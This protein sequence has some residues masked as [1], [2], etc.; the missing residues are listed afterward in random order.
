MDIIY[1]SAGSGK[2]TELVKRYINKIILGENP[3]NI[4]C[5][6][7][8]NNS[9]NDIKLKIIEYTKLLII[10]KNEKILEI[11]E[12]KKLSNKEIE[13]L[14]LFLI[15]IENIMNI[16]TIDSFLYKIL[17]FIDFDENRRLAENEEIIQIVNK[18]SNKFLIDNFKN[19]NEIETIIPILK[20]I[21]LNKRP[22][23]K[24]IENDLDKNIFIKKSIDKSN[25]ENKIKNKLNTF[26]N[27][28]I[29][30]ELSN[31]NDIINDFL[32][33]K[34]I[35]KYKSIDYKYK[36]GLSKNEQIDLDNIYLY[37]KAFNFINEHNFIIKNLYKYYQ[38]F[39]NLIEKEKQQKNIMDYNDI[40]INL[41]N[42]LKDNDNHQT[43][44][45]FIFNNI[46]HILVDEY[47]DTSFYQDEILTVIYELLEDGENNV[48]TF[49][50]IFLV[51][52]IKQSIYEWRDADSTIF[53]NKLEFIINRGNYQIIMDNEITL[54]NKINENFDKIIFNNS[55]RRLH[56]NIV[57]FINKKFE[58]LNMIGFMEHS[59]FRKIEENII[60]NIK[61][62][63]FCGDENER[64]EYIINDIL[65]NNKNLNDI[66]IISKNNDILNKIE[67]YILNNNIDLKFQKDNGGMVKTIEFEFLNSLFL[68][69]FLENNDYYLKKVLEFLFDDIDVINYFKNIHEN[70]NIQEF[71]N[72]LNII[73]NNNESIYTKLNQSIIE[74]DLYSIMFS[75]PNKINAISI[76]NRYIEYLFNI[77]PFIKNKN[78]FIERLLNMEFNSS[79]IS[80]IKD[81]ENAIHLLT[82]HK[83]KGL[84]FDT[85]YFLQEDL[86]EQNNFGINIING[87]IFNLGYTKSKIPFEFN[88][89]KKDKI[90]YEE[91]KKQEQL[92]L[93][94]VA[95]TRAKNNLIIL[96]K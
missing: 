24:K 46:G 93:Y 84:E 10:N 36:K 32:N 28:E 70:N 16:Y 92:K 50:T 83:S 61:E 15:D 69:I 94:Y 62:I 11:F 85:V 57:E 21:Y 56:P 64:I 68:S 53:Q 4:Y 9:V 90:E 14:K 96:N 5:L 27:N 25:L 77:L 39:E 51:G 71:I 82:I 79:L 72:K 42:I 7:F 87:K 95:L 60:S 30:K 40:I 91:I 41:N 48:S 54:D 52:D 12:N 76:L 23:F 89:Y 17:K 49:P 73:R 65:T 37:I 86:F 19:N 35:N 66:A 31:S 1:A 81:N 43:F 78:I 33:S 2:T 13:L 74:F 75:F 44:Q 58:K 55:T 34:L 38:T 88:S 67:N 26:N 20:N 6:T 63:E 45:Y 59:T 18:I 22:S 8:T 3:K 47:Q 29:F 80:N